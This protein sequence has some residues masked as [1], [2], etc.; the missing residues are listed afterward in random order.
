MYKKN[1]QRLLLRELAAIQYIGMDGVTAPCIA[2][3]ALQLSRSEERIQKAALLTCGAYH[4]FLL[5]TEYDGITAV[6]PGFASG[7]SGEGPSGLAAALMLLQRHNVDIEEYIVDQAFFERLGFSCLLERDVTAI[8]TDVPVRPQRWYDYVHPYCDEPDT[9][10]GLS[11]YYPLDL[12]LGLIDERIVD[13]ALKFRDDEDAAI[14][15]AFRRLEDILRK[16]TG[17]TGEGANLFSK[18]FMTDTAPLRWDVMDN[19]EAKGRA[20]LFSATYMAYRNAR[21]HREVELSSKG[22]FRE[23]LLVNELYLLEA[24][25]MTEAELNAKRAEY[26]SFEDMLQTLRNK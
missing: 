11:N 25:A 2:A 7:Y 23:F 20:S 26:V 8:K 6:K 21:V 12:P 18:V 14:I 5:F 4:G 1:N 22:A 19:G 13:L 3:I 10:N 16:R 9:E 15:S 17:L 24:E